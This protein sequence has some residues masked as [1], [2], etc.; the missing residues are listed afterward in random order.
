MPPL[1]PCAVRL[2][3]ALE[4][5]CLSHRSA[6][7]STRWPSAGACSCTR[8]VERAVL[9]APPLTALASRRGLCRL[10]AALTHSGRAA[11]PRRA[12][13]EAAVPLREEAAAADSAALGTQ[14]RHQHRDAHSAGKALQGRALQQGHMPPRAV[15]GLGACASSRCAW[16]LWAAQHSQRERRPTRAKPPPRVLEPA[17]SKGADSTALSHPGTALP[18]SFAGRATTRSCAAA[19]PSTSR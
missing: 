16:R 8:P 6:A 13:W 15:P 1:A 12:Q 19:P 2:R 3:S 18:P 4:T 5:S 7:P 14:V 9:G 11:A 10:R 17:A